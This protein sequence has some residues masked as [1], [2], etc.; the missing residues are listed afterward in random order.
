MADHTV[1]TLSA[2][3]HSE[4]TST[5]SPLSR[6]DGGNTCRTQPRLPELEHSRRPTEPDTHSCHAAALHLLLMHAL[7]PM[8][9][10]A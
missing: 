8:C 4:L 6:N 9:S 2:L 7:C 1:S 3:T 5:C 10:S